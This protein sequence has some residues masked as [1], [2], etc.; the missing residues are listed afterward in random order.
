MP[1][2]ETKNEEIEEIDSQ[3]YVVKRF[4]DKVVKI[5]ELNLLNIIS[6]QKKLYPYNL[7]QEGKMIPTNFNGIN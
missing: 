2:D 4:D 7:D 6:K 3:R 5:P 1:S